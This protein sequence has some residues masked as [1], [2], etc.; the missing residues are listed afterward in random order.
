MA[1]LTDT[2]KVR[3]VVHHVFLP[4]QLPQEGDEDS[5]VTL[6]DITS[7]ALVAIKNLLP[8][9]SHLEALDNS[10]VLLNN[11]RAINGLSGGKIDETRLHSALKT[12]RVGQTLVAN[13]VSQN[14]AVLVT[15]QSDQLVFEEF[16]LLPLAAAVNATRGRLTRTFPGLAVAVPAEILNKTD[17]LTM[18]ASTLS[19]M[20]HQQAPGTQ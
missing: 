19:T 7:Q 20:C 11:I 17:F 12:L 5:E 3:R 1:T 15:R 9:D 2:H 16:E 4:P 14:A 18:I 8:P 13:V 6:I 10:M